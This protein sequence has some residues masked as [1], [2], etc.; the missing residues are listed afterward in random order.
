VQVEWNLQVLHHHNVHTLW[1]SIITCIVLKIRSWVWFHF[2]GSYKHFDL[3]P[4]GRSPLFGPFLKFMQVIVDAI[5]V[6]KISNFWWICGLVLAS[7]HTNFYKIII[8]GLGIMPQKQNPSELR[9]AQAAKELF[10]FQLFWVGFI[11]K[12]SLQSS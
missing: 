7:R 1:E 2:R 12:N 9:A 11:F 6:Q 8:F 10:I 5:F 4:K 3:T